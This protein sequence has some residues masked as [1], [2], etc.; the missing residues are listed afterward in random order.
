MD[1]KYDYTEGVNC[2]IQT[3]KD[4]HYSLCCGMKIMTATDAKMKI[5]KDYIDAIYYSKIIAKQFDI[6]L[7]PATVN[8]LFPHGSQE[9]TQRYELKISPTLK[10]LIAEVEDKRPIKNP[11]FYIQ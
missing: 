1:K 7:N 10:L 3:A 4:P 2:L 8:M 5:E 6:K 9:N 11:I